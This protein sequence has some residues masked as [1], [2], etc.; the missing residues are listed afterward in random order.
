M[1]VSETFGVGWL[2]VKIQSNEKLF[3]DSTYCIYSFPYANESIKR[4]MR[5]NTFGYIGREPRCCYSGQSWRKR[6][7][8][9]CSTTTSLL[10]FHHSLI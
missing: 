9:C 10:R 7:T 3:V 4:V 6:R 8:V 2:E 5:E 1:Y